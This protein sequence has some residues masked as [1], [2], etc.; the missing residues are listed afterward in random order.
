ML[1]LFIKPCLATSHIGT[2]R[3]GRVMET[4]AAGMA[5][6]TAAGTV[7]VMAGTGAVAPS[8]S[9]RR[10]SLFTVYAAQPSLHALL[11]G[12]SIQP[13]IQGASRSFVEGSRRPSTGDAA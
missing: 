11:M 13:S 1:V 7:L 4:S 2:V 8:L 10:G 5:Q 6:A 9:C 3:T 12:Y